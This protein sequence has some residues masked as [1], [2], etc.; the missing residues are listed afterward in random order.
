VISPTTVAV[1]LGGSWLRLAAAE[2]KKRSLFLWKRK[3]VAVTELATLL[4]TL[5]VQKRWNNVQ[6][7][8]VG[9][10]GIWTL[11]ERKRVAQSIAQLANHV[12]VMSDIELAFHAALGRKRTETQGILIVA[13][14][15]SM[16][17]GITRSGRLIRAGGNGPMKG[18]KGSGWWIGNCFQETTPPLTPT[19]IRATAALAKRVLLRA[20]DD[21]RCAT[22]VRD[23]QNHLAT[24]I[25]S[26]R[27]RMNVSR[28]PVSWGGSLMADH[29]FRKG[30]FSAL[31]RWDSHPYDYI[32]PTEP[33]EQ[34]AARHPS[35]IPQ[36]PPTVVPPRLLTKKKRRPFSHNPTA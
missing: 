6:R 24:L 9:S 19:T 20:T 2:P 11:S 4:H 3:G 7:L 31:G 29:R 17:L 21:S 23:A 27:K 16:A 14:T 30:V 15:G 18:E 35:L 32:D 25:V 26:V 8:I 1:D 12:T 5:W 36:R 13:G 22:I 34:R 33:P 28:V 10:K